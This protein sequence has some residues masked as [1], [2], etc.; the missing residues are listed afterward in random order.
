ML[1]FHLCTFRKSRIFEGKLFIKKQRLK[2]GKKV[3]VK[4]EK[5]E[6]YPEQEPRKR[7]TS[8]PKA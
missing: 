4:A 8:E 5:K 7:K 3:K 2:K 6:N 1:T